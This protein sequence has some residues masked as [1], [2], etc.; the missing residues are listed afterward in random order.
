MQL[1]LLNLKMEKGRSKKDE[2]LKN[3]WKGQNIINDTDT[4]E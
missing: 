4:I 1:Q 3:D 2:F